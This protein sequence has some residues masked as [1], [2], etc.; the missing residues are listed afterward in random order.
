MQDGE[1]YCRVGRNPAEFR[2]REEVLIS[3]L[4]VAASTA[5]A[6]LQCYS[7]VLRFHS[8]EMVPNTTELDD[9]LKL[10]SLRVRLLSPT[11]DGTGEFTSQ[12]KL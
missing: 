8:F 4:Q 7:P 11:E 12:E 1:F 3:V 5:E 9:C 6:Y 2:R 10:V